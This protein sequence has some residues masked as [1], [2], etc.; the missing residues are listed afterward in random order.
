[1][2]FEEENKINCLPTNPIKESGQRNSKPTI[3]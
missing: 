1:M 3:F 2:N